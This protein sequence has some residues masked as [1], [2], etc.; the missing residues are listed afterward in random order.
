MLACV[1]ACVCTMLHTYA[2]L[3]IARH[4]GLMTPHARG[5]EN[6][7]IH[8]ALQAM[9][10]LNEIDKTP[11]NLLSHRMMGNIWMEA[12]IYRVSMLLQLVFVC[13]A[14]KGKDVR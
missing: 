1:R 2:H 6:A 5:W 12:Y 14:R 9:N 4:I 3:F 11:Q 13:C 10:G 7:C 8:G